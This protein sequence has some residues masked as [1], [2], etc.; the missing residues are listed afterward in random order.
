MKQGPLVVALVAALAACNGSQ[1]GS[2]GAPSASAAGSTAAAPSAST[3]ASATAPVAST[4]PKPALVFG[5]TAPSLELNAPG[6]A[7]GRALR[8]AATGAAGGRALAITV[9]PPN[10]VSM[11]MK[12]GLALDAPEAGA[13]LGFH[14]DHVDLAMNRDV[15]EGAQKTM[16]GRFEKDFSTVVGR[17]DLAEGRSARFTQTGG[18]ATTPPI[19]WVLLMLHVPLPEAPVGKGAKWHATQPIEAS[20]RKGTQKT[21]YELVALDGDRIEVELH[22]EGEWKA[23]GGRATGTTK[24]DAT[25][26][27]D[28]ASPITQ[29]AGGRIVENVESTQQMMAS[30]DTTLDVEI[31][32][33]P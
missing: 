28:L 5:A 11:T 21:S 3:V 8:Y 24:V 15:P 32:P 2:S 23:V 7:P 14:I 18:G 33:R 27:I 25:V 31:S 1:G 19:P 10:K 26:T 17:V 12:L 9:T 16:L 22:G 30:G 4:R 6:A 20:G 29:K 13:A